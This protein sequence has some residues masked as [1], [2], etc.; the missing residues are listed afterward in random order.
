MRGL[1]SCQSSEPGRVSRILVE[2][3]KTRKET[4]SE[5]CARIM[6]VTAKEGGRVSSP[7]CLGSPIKGGKKSLSLIPKVERRGPSGKGQRR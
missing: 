5:R 3:W 6:Q 2:D 7:D 1:P 4:N